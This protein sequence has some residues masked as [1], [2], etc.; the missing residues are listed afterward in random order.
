MDE[1]RAFYNNPGRKVIK[2]RGPQTCGIRLTEED[3]TDD[4]N[5]RQEHRR[6]VLLSGTDYAREIKENEIQ[7]YLR[8]KISYIDSYV[9]F[10]FSLSILYSFILSVEWNRKRQL[11]EYV[12]RTGVPGAP[13]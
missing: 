7:T 11:G 3:N 2:L 12:P 5:R 1:L 6:T 13:V 8:V 4:L 9:S 10:N